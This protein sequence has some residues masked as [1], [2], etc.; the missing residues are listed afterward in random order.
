MRR[1]LED[2]FKGKLMPAIK[3]TLLDIV[4]LVAD[5]RN[6][7]TL[8]IPFLIDDQAAQIVLVISAWNQRKKIEPTLS[9]CTKKL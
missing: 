6:A 7:D 8:S 5:T 2:I 3:V 9:T 4:V 1:V